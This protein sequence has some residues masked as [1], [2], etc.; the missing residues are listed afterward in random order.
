MGEWRKTV[1]PV[2]KKYELAAMLGMS[3]SSN[4]ESCAAKAQLL[5]KMAGIIDDEIDRRERPSRTWRLFGLRITVTR[6]G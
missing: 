1:D 2:V 4:A 6:D 5:L 3:V